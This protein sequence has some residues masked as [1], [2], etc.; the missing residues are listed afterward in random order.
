MK[1]F[2]H[3]FC[4][5]RTC[6]FKGLAKPVI[7]LQLN[8]RRIEL[9]TFQ[10]PASTGSFILMTSGSM[11]YTQYHPSACRNTPMQT[12]VLTKITGYIND[13]IKGNTE[14]VTYLLIGSSFTHTPY[15]TILTFKL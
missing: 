15:L 13:P 11:P 1:Y 9:I 10:S 14:C 5:L 6:F 12:A 4:Q 8:S 3:F 2:K 7:E